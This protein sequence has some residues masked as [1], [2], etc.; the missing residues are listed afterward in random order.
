MAATD[1]PDARRESLTALG[2]DA[3]A[4]VRCSLA[5]ART[6]VVF[7]AGPPDAE[8]MVVGEAPGFHE[9]RLGVPFAGPGGAL[10]DGLLGSVGLARGGVYLATVVQCRPPGNRDLQDAEVAACEGWLFRQVAL[11]R[12]LLVLALGS[13]AT[14][15][16]SGRPE[17]VA[18]LRGRPQE[19]RIGDH[20]AVLL[21]L[22]DPAAAQY[23]PSMRETLAADIA[24]VPSCSPARAA[25]SRPPA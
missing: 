15:V 25:R 10:L 21:P 14:R 9:D 13:V 19:T 23:T 8:V 24:L 5:D 18:A 12:P 22:Y 11:V 6:S 20:A 1:G 16:L 4:C 2:R 17:T 3:A 7:G